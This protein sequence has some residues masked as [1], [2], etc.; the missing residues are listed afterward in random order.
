MRA[1][2]SLESKCVPQKLLDFCFIS[3]IQS[4]R[5][6]CFSP[7]TQVIKPCCQPH[8]QTCTP[9]PLWRAPFSSAPPLTLYSF[10]FT[11]P[12]VT[13]HSL[14]SDSQL[15][16]KEDQITPMCILLKDLPQKCLA[17]RNKIYP[18]PPITMEPHERWKTISIFSITFHFFKTK[19]SHQC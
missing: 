4:V 12:L 19:K 16:V 18:W 10:I 13:K 6:F 17:W 2:D 14:K 7:L 15:L 3:Q 8:S 5:F 11:A 9:A 1:V